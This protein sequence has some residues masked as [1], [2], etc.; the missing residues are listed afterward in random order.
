ML[1]E[2]MVTSLMISRVRHLC[3]RHLRVLVGG[4]S[5]IIS[6]IIDKVK[7]V[8]VSFKILQDFRLSSSNLEFRLYLEA[9]VEGSSPSCS[10]GWHR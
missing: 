9:G 5:W 10:L 7:G 6:S 3:T 1:L 2:V 4:L 8:F